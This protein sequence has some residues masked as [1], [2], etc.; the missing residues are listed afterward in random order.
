MSIQPVRVIGRMIDQVAGS[1]WPSLEGHFVASA[2]G[3]GSYRFYRAPQLERY[4]TPF[5]FWVHALREERAS[6]GRGEDLVGAA[7]HAMCRG[8]ALAEFI[9]QLDA[10]PLADGARAT[11][12]LGLASVPATVRGANTA[13]AARSGTMA[14]DM[15]ESACRRSGLASYDGYL[16]AYFWGHGFVESWRSAGISAGMSAG[17]SEGVR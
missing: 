2:D 12:I 4:A 9:A 5:H 15:L 14:Y 1:D 3:T 7:G 16:V 8:I 13:A 17:V 6:I 11:E 10:F